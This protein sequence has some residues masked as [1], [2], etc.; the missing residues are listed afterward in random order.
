MLQLALIDDLDKFNINIDFIF[1][2][3]IKLFT[4]LIT[5]YSG[6]HLEKLKIT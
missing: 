5:T 4:S 3:E 6:E 1:I 2:S